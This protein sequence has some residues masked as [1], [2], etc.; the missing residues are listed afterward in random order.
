MPRTDDPPH[1]AWRPF[2]D[3]WTV[4]ADG[5]QPIEVA[6]PH[7]AMLAEPRSAD[8]P[9]GSG[10]GYFPGGLYTYHK[11]WASPDVPAGHR[12]LLR[13]EGIS[14]VSTVVV[15]GTE[16]GGAPNAYRDFEVDVTD[17]LRPGDE[18]D[19]EVIADNTEQP[20][21]RW[22]T[23]SGIHRP[24]WW[25]LRGPITL[26]KHGVRIRTMSITSPALVEVEL[27]FTNPDR[28]TVQARVELASGGSVVA[29]EYAT[30]DGITA[31]L[32]LHVPEPQLWSA[33][34]PDL[35]DCTV[36]LRADDEIVDERRSRI[37]LR[38]VALD[39]R[40]GLLINDTPVLLRG[41][42]IHH[43]N[44]VIGSLA[45]PAAEHR[46]ARILKE[47]GFNAIRSAH[48]PLSQAMLDACDEIGLYVMD[49][50]TDVWWNAKTRYD[51]SR[52]FLDQWRIDLDEMVLRDRN[53][54]S[55]I[56]FSISNENGETAARAGIELARSMA[57]RIDELD[58]TRPVTAGVNIAINALASRDA[59]PPTGTTPA[60]KTLME[61][62]DS[63]SFNVAMQFL[64]PAMSVVT[65]TKRADLGTR[66]IFDILDIAGY[67]YGANR[68]RRDAAAHPA[69]IMVGTEDLPGDIARIWPL[70]E[71]IPNLIGDF[72][73]AG[74]DYLGETG[75]GHWLYHR[76]WAPLLKP[77]PFV[78]SGCGVIDITGRPGAPA[79]LARA[80]WSPATPPAITV[81][82]LD[83]SEYRAAKATWRP[84]D[85]IDSWSWAGRD[86]QPAHVEVYSAAEEVELLLDGTSIGRAAAGTAHG[87]VARFSLPYRPGEL[88][89]VARSSGGRIAESRLRSA[90]GPLRLILR[91]ERSEL[92]ADGNDLA[93]I[94]VEIADADGVIESL[95]DDLVT[96]SIDGPAVLAGFGSAA[97][98]T[99]ESFADNTHTT[100][101]GRALAVV[102][103]TRV[104]GSVR[105]T[106]TS[107]RHG[108]A[109]CDLQVR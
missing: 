3:R 60:G 75:V 20:N 45:L 1:G 24:V 53:H 28:R 86:G 87:F 15:N 52:T 64:V 93:Y 33:D 21:S 56:M 106:A 96:L 38:T 91:A 81:R 69:R 54:P 73:W 2:G 9:S 6:L 94:A 44:G 68:F 85:A 42:N 78:T 74:W 37:G 35:Y 108:T 77:Y 13:F 43:D 65:A 51:D 57:A 59:T 76:R 70:V 4:T 10:G 98:A 100:Y 84:S 66:G 92:A 30:T 58:G 62:V 71:K 29:Q 49:E 18:N 63:T 34:N 36:V 101:Y 61:K 95:A 104:P 31:R 26:G 23:G 67:N 7:D 72:L 11:R 82:P 8:A 102:R 41:G 89:A 39:A 107:A 22:Y 50:T 88:V 14:R 27:C 103:A 12:V 99:E 5:G 97:P 47:N 109:M 48:N 32:V 17:V 80:V 79:A 90:Q 16:L 46:R 40:R 19:I 105:I 83:I 55:V 25:Q